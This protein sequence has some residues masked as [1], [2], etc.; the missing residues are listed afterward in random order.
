[1]I[2]NGVIDRDF[3]ATPY[4]LVNLFN[5]VDIGKQFKL[6]THIGHNMNQIHTD[7]RQPFLL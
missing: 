4:T 1:M 5:V 2:R 6:H 3:F 7:E